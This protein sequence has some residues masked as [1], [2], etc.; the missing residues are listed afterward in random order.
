MSTVIRDAVIRLRYEQGK[1]ESTP[2]VRA[3]QEHQKAAK[4]TAKAEKEVAVAVK[5]TV[6]VSSQSSQRMVANFREAGEGALRFARGLAFLSASGSEDLKKLV[7]TVAIAQ[8]AFDV[9]AGGFKVFTNLAVTFGNPVALAVTGVTTAIGAGAA[10][11][12]RWRNEA[13]EAKK[14]ALEVAKAVME[15]E[16]ARREAVAAGSRTA[17][18][19]IAFRDQ[20]AITDAQR[21]ALQQRERDEVAR[22]RRVLESEF[23]RNAPGFQRDFYGAIGGADQG[24]LRAA[25]DYEKQR[26]EL[27]RRQLDLDKEKY[28]QDRKRL[29]EQS[30]LAQQTIGAGVPGLGAFLGGP[31]FFQTQA[32]AITEHQSK[33][34][35]LIAAQSAALDKMIGAYEN[36]QTHIRRLEIELGAANDK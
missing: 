28:E 4:E 7:Q 21:A 34:D 16:A 14:A 13:E 19:R 22:A 9:F 35:K 17:F 5:E 8:G 25:L 12:I 11:W 27:T 23:G 36:A 31:S 1:L 33:L 26:A 2:A 29:T 6:A 32:Q 24:Q 30:G 18:G 15:I 3:H 10:A 20:F